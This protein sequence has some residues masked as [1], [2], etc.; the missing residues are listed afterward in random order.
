ML[1][2][3][4]FDILLALLATACNHIIFPEF[5]GSGIQAISKANELLSGMTVCRCGL[6]NDLMANMLQIGK[7][8]MHRFF[9]PYVFLM[10]AILSRTNLKPDIGFL[11][12]SI[13]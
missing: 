8:T 1:S 3:E 11:P 9:A 5:K 6:Y 4:K 2:A 12:C 13:P 10:Q 7:S